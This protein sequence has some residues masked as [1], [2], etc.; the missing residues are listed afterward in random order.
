[1]KD[2]L[3]GARDQ[4]LW[5]PTAAPLHRPALAVEPE[6]VLMD[7]P[8]SALDPIATLQI[9]DLIKELEKRYTVV[10]VTHNMQQAARVAETTAFFFRE[11]SSRLALLP[12]YSPTRQQTDRG[13]HH[14]ALWIS[15]CRLRPE[16]KSI[17]SCGAAY[18]GRDDK[19]DCRRPRKPITW[20]RKGRS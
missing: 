19:L 18:G 15:V 1:M 2:R 3:A 9:E 8:C 14:W 13:L 10:I 4:P 5:R 17:E 7:E 20:C 16:Q 11:S 6:I 12:N